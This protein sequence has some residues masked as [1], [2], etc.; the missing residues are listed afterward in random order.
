[1]TRINRP[2]ILAETLGMDLAELLP[3]WAIDNEYFTVSKTAPKPSEVGGEEYEWSPLV[4]QFFAQPHG[5]VVWAAKAPAEVGREYSDR[6][7]P[8][9]DQ[10]PSSDLN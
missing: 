7:M 3:L 10:R 1:M 4:D 9:D 8:S 5:T 6:Q 2:R